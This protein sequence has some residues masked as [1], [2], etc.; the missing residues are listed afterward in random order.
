M[1]LT[2]M[3]GFY[4]DIMYASESAQTNVTRKETAK[5]ETAKRVEPI[6]IGDIQALDRYLNGISSDS[7]IV[8]SINHR[9][10]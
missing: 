4:S 6:N 8:L 10:N 9:A 2:A 7:S 5:K 1:G 3:S